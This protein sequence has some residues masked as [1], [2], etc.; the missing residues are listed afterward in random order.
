MSHEGCGQVQTSSGKPKKLKFDELHLS[1]IYIPPTKALH[2]EDLS[3]LIS[4]ICSPNSQIPYVIF[5]TISRFSRL[6][7]SVFFELKSYI[8]LTKIAHQSK[9]SDLPLF[10]LKFT[11]LLI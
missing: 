6:N 7:S 11:K 2:T 8:L 9:F 3:T 10:P 5:E 4:T 1:K